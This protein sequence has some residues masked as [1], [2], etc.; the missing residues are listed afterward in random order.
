MANALPFGAP[1]PRL[2]TRPL[3]F[4]CRYWS[5]AAIGGCLFPVQGN[6]GSWRE[7]RLA[8]GQC[9]IASSATWQE[10]GRH[11]PNACANANGIDAYKDAPCAAEADGIVS[12]AKARDGRNHAALLSARQVGASRQ[13]V[14]TGGW[15]LTDA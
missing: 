12:E 13:L 7:P 6:G 3:P 15:P 5:H 1:R 14:A 11:S 10:A 9:H 4:P 2:I 8:E